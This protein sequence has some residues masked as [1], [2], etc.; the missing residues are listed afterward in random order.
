MFSVTVSDVGAVVTVHVFITHV[1]LS[2]CRNTTVSRG[3]RAGP[4]GPACTQSR[5]YLMWLPRC[6]MSLS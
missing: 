4:T 1:M 6:L 3:A 2:V 5:V